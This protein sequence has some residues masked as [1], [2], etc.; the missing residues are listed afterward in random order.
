MFILTEKINLPRR[1]QLFNDYVAEDAAQA[2]R[3]A[4]ERWINRVL[5][6]A[7]ALIRIARK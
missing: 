7:A 2:K 4:D 1:V 5:D 6:A 3:E